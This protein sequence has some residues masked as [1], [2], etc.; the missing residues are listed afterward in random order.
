MMGVGYS[1]DKLFVF[2]KCNKLHSIWNNFSFQW[3][4]R[5][6]IFSPSPP[7]LTYEGTLHKSIQSSWVKLNPAQLLSSLNIVLL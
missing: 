1:Q 5:D 4:H 2:V 6:L 7:N 3:H